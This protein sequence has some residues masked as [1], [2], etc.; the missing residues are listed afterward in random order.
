M[1]K[2]WNCFCSKQCL[3]KGSNPCYFSVLISFC[4]WFSTFRT[5]PG[6]IFGARQ[7]EKFFKIKTSLD[8]NISSPSIMPL[9][10]IK[11]LSQSQLFI[12]CFKRLKPLRTTAP[13]LS[14]QKHTLE[15]KQDGVNQSSE[16]KRQTLLW[17]KAAPE[18]LSWYIAC[19]FL[20]NKKII[21]L[22]LWLRSVVIQWQNLSF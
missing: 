6:L 17:C 2:T 9:A 19:A 11:C 21:A 5:F 4:R 7:H 1:C 22:R 8:D 10:E 15:S 14:S 18:G 12:L 20:E 16:K 3:G 13:W